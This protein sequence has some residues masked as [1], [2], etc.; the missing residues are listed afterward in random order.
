MTTISEPAT[1]HGAQVTDWHADEAGDCCRDLYGPTRSLMPHA[2]VTTSARQFRDNGEVLDGY[3]SVECLCGE[4]PVPAA[5]EL[6]AALLAAADE[7][8]GR[9][10]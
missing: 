5:R 9:R 8:E 6:A 4:M 2:V 10:S 7:V 3:V 1:P